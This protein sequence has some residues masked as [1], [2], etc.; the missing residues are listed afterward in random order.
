M[1]NVTRYSVGYEKETEYGPYAVV[2]VCV[3]KVKRV[4]NDEDVR[5]LMGRHVW[6]F[7]TI[8]C[9]WTGSSIARV[10]Q[11]IRYIGGTII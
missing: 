8:I 3:P 11:R 6:T 2:H 4:H 5:I 1:F 10:S 9:E 7:I